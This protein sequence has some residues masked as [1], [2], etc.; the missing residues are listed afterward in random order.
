ME[1]EEK[2]CGKRRAEELYVFWF[3]LHVGRPIQ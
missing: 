1:P 3:I 2:P